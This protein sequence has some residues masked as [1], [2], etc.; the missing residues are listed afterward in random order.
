M[1]VV[2]WL[3]SFSAE[4]QEIK[5][6]VLDAQNKKPIQ[7]ANVIFA[8][9]RGVVTN[10][11]GFFSFNTSETPEVIKISSLGYEVLEIDPKSITNEVVFL[12]PAS[13]E[14]KEVF[15]SDK[16]L[17]P[18]EIMKKVREGITTNYDFNLSKK[19]IFFRQSD[20]NYVRKFGL[21]VDESTIEG[22]D[23]N[24]MDRISS[25]VPKVSDSYK[26]VLADLYGNY[27]SQKLRIIK[28]ANL[29]NPQ[30]TQT[31][32]D[33]TDRLETLFKQNLKKNSY[34]KIR[35]G[36]VG[37]KVDAKELQEELEESREEN[38]KKEKTAEE[39]A[40]EQIE[41]QKNLQK[42]TAQKLNSVLGDMFW[43]EDNTFDLFDKLNRYKYTMDGYAYI[44]NATVY[45]IN[46]EPRWRG[47]FKGKVYVNTADYGVHRLEFENVKPLKKFRLFGISALD[48]VYRG[49]MI[50]VK[51]ENGKYQLSYLEREKGESVG[52]DRPLTIIEKNK[53]VPGRRKQNELDLD[54]DLR[55]SQ[56]QRLQL[57]V[58]DKE[59]LEPAQYENLQSPGD[60]IYEKFKVYNPEFWKGNNIIEPNA[61][62][63]Q[64]T[65]L[66][67]E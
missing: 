16:S 30:S 45:V 13:I 22:I 5:A 49:R 43:K 46:F 2:C 41:S 37:V 7:Y 40:K 4:A 50:F 47:D 23:Q 38:Q 65:A 20:F 61:A 59:D 57:V 29:H 17:S 55:I 18:K 32:T 11:E 35:S 10:E 54:I 24:L 3:F 15:L 48:D 42:R 64:F 21:H 9:H 25:E 67:A 51:D 1:L 63:K 39:I 12:V 36:I 53:Y 19:R 58:Y 52:I 44:D 27:D 31:L 66:G 8:E 62:I 26:E 14:L 33:L 60:F 6:R 34:L 56:V 28:A